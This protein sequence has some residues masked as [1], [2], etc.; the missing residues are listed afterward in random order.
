MQKVLNA[1]VRFIFNVRKHEHITPYLRMAHFLPVKQR[2][3]YKLCTPA[4]KIVNG[5]ALEYLADVVRL[6]VP[7]RQ[8]RVGRDDLMLETT[9]Q[10]NTIG[11]KLSLT[12]NLLPR[13]LRCVNN[14]QTFKKQLKTFFLTKHLICKF[15]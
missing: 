7:G 11:G 10:V 2:I 15:I 6:F 5:H 12:W 1:S 14:E 9:N 13:D 8:L 4:F 3:Q